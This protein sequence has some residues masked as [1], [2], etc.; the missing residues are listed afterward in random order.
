[1]RV[2]VCG[3]RTYN[4][5]YQF[6]EAMKLLPTRPTLIIQGG[7]KGADSLAGM[8]AKDQGVF[9]IQMDALWK[10]HGNG[11]GPK[12]NQA[13]I[14]IG[15]PDYCVAFPGGSGTADMIRR[16]EFHGVPVWRPYG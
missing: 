9:A 15:K 6:D 11:A 3:G 16:C 7:A 13:M 8:W 12:R 14:D 10:A 2:L 4:D 1:M 5:H